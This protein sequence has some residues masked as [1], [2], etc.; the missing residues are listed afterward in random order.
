M[1]KPS[2]KIVLAGASGFIGSFLFNVLKNNF[3]ITSLSHSQSSF[4]EN[5]VLLD[6][7]DEEGVS[8][9][10]EDAPIFDVLI[11]L[12]GLAHEKG[13]GKD[14]SRFRQI[15]KQTLMNLTLGLDKKDRLPSKIIFAS[16]ISIYGEKIHQK[17]YYEDSKTE[18]FSP[19]AITKL[20]AEEFLL[21]YYSSQSW[22]L[23][24]APVYSPDFQLNLERRTKI[25]DMHYRIGD[26]TNRLSLCNVENI[27]I[28]INS[29]LD[30]KVPAGVFNISDEKEY[31]YND[32][33]CHVNA[34][35]IV[36][37]PKFLVIGLYHIGKIINNIF[38]TENT[39]KLISDN[40]FPSQ[41]I[42]KYIELSAKLN[43]SKAC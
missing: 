28:V 40:V 25:K 29:I 23:R 34:K 36:Y 11:F 33:L 10:V 13:R 17:F 9:F 8:N 21:K 4:K 18:P 27:S 35:W 3:S 16:T 31:S 32:L 2:D 14:I 19:Y 20:E 38:L 42:M 22:I 39:I 30:G 6:L 43:E 37:I 5:H 41:K 12:V 24:F 7:T 1:F 15:N 26:G